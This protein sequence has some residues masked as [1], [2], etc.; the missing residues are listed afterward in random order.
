MTTIQKEI[1]AYLLLSSSDDD[2]S[3]EELLIFERIAQPK[4]ENLIPNVVHKFTNKQVCVL[5]L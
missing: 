3:D 5:R 1:V 4:I 2:E